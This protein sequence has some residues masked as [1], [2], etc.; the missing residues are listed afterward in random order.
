MTLFAGIDGGQSSTIAVVA[1]ETGR[2]L[3]RGRAGAADE[4]AQGAESTRLHDALARALANACAAAKIDSQ[5]RFR[6]IVAG[7]SGYEGKVYGKWPELGAEQL[8]LMH[9]A[10]IAHSGAFAGGPGIVVIA[11][12]GSVAYGVDSSD[13]CVTVGG[14]G[15]LF[16]DEGSAFWLARETLADAMCESDAEVEND[17]VAPALAYFEMPSLRALARAFYA[18]SIARAKLAGFAV[19]IVRSA[20]N[21]SQRAAQ[22]CREAAGALATL[23]ANAASRLALQSPHVAFIGGLTSGATMREAIARAVTERLPDAQVV[24]P[25]YDPAIGALLLAYKSAGLDVRVVEEA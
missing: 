3:A 19:E 1:D 24:Q 8:T 5:T 6:A 18:G 10:P 4:V 25:Q 7:V 20:E 14:W 23:A 21:G 11:G 15:Y 17:L 16:G 9:D 22:A 13:A 2:V 12:T